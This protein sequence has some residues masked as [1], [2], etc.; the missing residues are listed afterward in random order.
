MNCS[1]P[2]QQKLMLLHL[3]SVEKSHMGAKGPQFFSQCLITD[4]KNSFGEN[5]FVT[6]KLEEQ[7]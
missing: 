4:V 1:L 2:T 3:S 5:K 7:S 6:W